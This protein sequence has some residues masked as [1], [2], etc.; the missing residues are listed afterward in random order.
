[1]TQEAQRR[2]SAFFSVTTLAGGASGAI[3]YRI[4]DLKGLRGLAT[5]QWI[6]II[7]GIVTAGCAIILYFT[8]AD[9][10]EEARFLKDNERKFLKEKL[11][12]HSGI[13]SGF[14]TKNNISD[15]SRTFIDYL[16]WIPSLVYFGLIV[17]SYGY[18]YF[19]ATIVKE[20]GYTA[21]SAN[22]HSIYPWICAFGFSNII[23][24][25]S[26]KVGRRLPFLIATC[27]TAIVG[28]ALILGATHNPSARYAGCFLAASGLYTAMPLIVCWST[29]NY[30][31]H[32][33]KS[34]G[35]AWQ[36]GFGNIGGIIS[37]FL[38]LQKDA[39]VYAPG[40][41]TSIAF[42]VF[43]ICFLLAYFVALIYANRKK[44]KPAYKE[45]FDSL[46]EREKVLAGDKNPEFTYTY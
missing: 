33:R 24:F 6:F 34:M 12:I 13:P 15:I 26:D 9:F 4:N 28:L 2:F 25:I 35:T 1:M 18:A 17:P 38:F 16:V 22:Q 39:P 36:I 46:S 42:T 10:P 37:T 29:L 30:G 7:D 31:G 19:S 23:S 20:M 40:L 43:S 45:K 8:L 5:W 3:S 44:Q 41:G 21:V 27:C 14:E 11:E 32:L